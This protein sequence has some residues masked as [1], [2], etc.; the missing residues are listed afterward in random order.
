MN[1]DGDILKNNRIKKLTLLKETKFLSLYEAEYENKKGKLKH[2]ITASR[3][4][5]NSLNAQYFHGEKEKMDAV[6]IAAFHTDLN[7]LVCIKQ[8]RVPLNDYVY[9]LPA[10]L[11]DGDESIEAAARRELKEE[12][13]F[14]LV[15]VDYTKTKSGVYASAGMTDESAALVFCS[16]K[17]EI[18]KDYMEEDEDID[19]V[20]L[21]Q[22]EAKELLKKDVKMDMR[23][24]LMLHY[25][26]DL[27]ANIIK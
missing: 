20:L 22:D 1:L 26:A 12:T 23:V 6:I 15:E 18:S 8:F 13:G 7:K 19:V 24:F 27:G 5:L 4:N 9:E 17:G 11:I 14:D 16:C 25:F 2:W 21:S 3:K 10:G